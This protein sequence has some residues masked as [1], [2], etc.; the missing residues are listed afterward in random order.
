MIILPCSSASHSFS[1]GDLTAITVP[2]H[3]HEAIW[4]KLVSPRTRISFESGINWASS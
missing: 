4:Y 2:D 3:A 1:A